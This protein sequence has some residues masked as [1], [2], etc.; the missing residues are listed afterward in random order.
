MG[1]E[2]LADALEHL[3]RIAVRA[4][5]RLVDD[6]VDDA[7]A[8]RSRAVSLSAFAASAMRFASPQRIAAQPSGEITE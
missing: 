8:L 2:P 4:A 3:G 7:Q 5:D 1:F 6:L